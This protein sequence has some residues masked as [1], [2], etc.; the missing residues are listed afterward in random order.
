MRRGLEPL[1]SIVVPFAEAD[2]PAL[3]SCIESVLAQVDP[4]WEL[5]L[6]AHGPIGPDA[7]ERVRA[8]TSRDAWIRFVGFGGED[9]AAAMNAALR[10]ARGRLV[11]V[12]A[13]NELLARHALCE[14]ARAVAKRP[15]LDVIYTDEDSIDPS[16][17]HVDPW[18]K[19]GWSPDLLLAHDY[20]GGAYAFRRELLTLAGGPR[21]GF[22]GAERY[23]LLLRLTEHASAIARIPTVLVHRTHLARPTS[24]AIEREGDAAEVRAVASALARRSVDAEATP[25]GPGKR[26]IRY[27]IGAPLV[28]IVIPTRDRVGLLRTCVSSI[29]DRSTYRAFELLVIDNGSSEREALAF[30]GQIPPPHRVLLDARPFNWS[31]LNNRAV[32]HARGDHLVF[33]NNDVEVISPDW[34]EAMVEHAQR[35]EVG[36]VGAKLLYPNDTVQHS[37]LVVGLGGFADHAFRGAPACAPGY[38]GLASVVRNTSGV[39]GACMMVRRSVFTELGGFD[40]RLRVAFND[41]DFC[42]RARECGLLV[43][44]TP[45]AVL[46]HHESATRGPLHPGAEYRFMRRRWS[47]VIEAGDPYY[48]PNL[49]LDREDYGL[50]E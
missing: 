5:L 27:A 49:T 38:R 46:R 47:D 23:D 20:I 1:A 6:V 25:I 15:D 41:V 30:L 12:L 8:W 16:G 24:F 19:P 22:A 14:I 28:S 44:Q 31:A 11:V 48:N 37:G 34:L 33:L 32:M 2:L 10:S 29:L 18:M 26:R 39:T 50:R 42:L 45:H 35:A 13:V 3:A 36:V 4:R 7:E 17:R 21:P 43:V 40:E 9:V